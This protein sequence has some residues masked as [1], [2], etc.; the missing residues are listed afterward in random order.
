[1][2]NSRLWLRLK[3]YGHELRA[4][5]AMRGSRLSMTGNIMGHELSALDAMNNFGLW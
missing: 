4:L 1:M 2:N 3:T 5:D